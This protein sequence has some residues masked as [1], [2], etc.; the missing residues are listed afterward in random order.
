[1]IMW[2]L[3]V[4]GLGFLLGVTVKSASAP[5]IC[6]WNPSEIFVGKTC[7][8]PVRAV[9]FGQ[10]GWQREGRKFIEKGAWR[11]PEKCVG[12]TC[13]FSN[14]EIGGG[15]VLVTAE[16]HAKAV[17]EF[18]EVEEKGKTSQPFEVAD[19]PGKGIGLV[20][21][22]DIRKGE[23]IMTRVPTMLIEQRPHVQMDPD[24]RGRL[25]E[26]AVARLPA[27]RREGFM[28]QM[29]E[30]IYDKIETNC[31]QIFTD[32]NDESGHLGCFPEISRFN[33]DCR[34]NVHYRLNNITHTTVAV[35]DIRAGDEL[36]ISYIDVLQTREKR[37]YRLS[38]WGFNCTCSQC[39]LPANET[40]ASDARIGAIEKLKKDMEN[41]NETVVSAE[42]GAVLV[43]LYEE[44]R[45]HSYLG[46]AYTRAALNYAL[47][48][49]YE[50]AQ[51]YARTAVEALQ[52]EFGPDHGDI[53]P[54]RIL[55]EDPKKHWTYGKVRA[56]KQPKR[57]KV[58]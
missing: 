27:S 6:S 13:I 25:Y 17:S 33:H 28:G 43:A 26:A 22:R 50:K 23:T 2:M 52:R 10:L 56:T 31:F 44:E 47:F 18:S 3:R 20:A 39:S 16:N 30:D 45:L 5:N 15:I 51:E 58:Y 32:A 14:S 7:S 12:K 40:R 35:R 41:F 19:I 49:E 54:M 38:K 57:N 8:N 46:H 9:D 53:K 55:A 42:T 21:T 29:G 11:G 1:M 4:Y 34:P 37:Q 48:G 36:S 24:I